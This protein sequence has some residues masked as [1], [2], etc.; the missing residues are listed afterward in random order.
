M[1]YRVMKIQQVIHNKFVY[2][3]EQRKSRSTKGRSSAASDMYKRQLK[4]RGIQKNFDYSVL[5]A[6][7]LAYSGAGY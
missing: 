5:L 3:N 7:G 6:C 1:G 4:E 2:L